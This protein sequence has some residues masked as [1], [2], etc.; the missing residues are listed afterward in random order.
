[1]IGSTHRTVAKSLDRLRQDGWL[2]TV[3]RR[4]QFGKK[5]AIYFPAVPD[6]VLLKNGESL[7]A[8]AMGSPRSPI[9]LTIGES[10]A[11]QS[12]ATV[13]KAANSVDSPVDKLSTNGE[14][15]HGIG[16]SGLE[17][18][19]PG[20]PRNLTEIK[21]KRAASPRPANAGDAALPPEAIAAIARAAP[22]EPASQLRRAG[23]AATAHQVETVRRVG[24]TETKAVQAKADDSEAA[25]IAK[26]Q[27][28][29]AA[30]PDADAATLCVC[31]PGA[32]VDEVERARKSNGGAA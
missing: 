32:T 21:F 28:L 16:E 27:K 11:P 10:I 17:I 29:R 4:R 5:G 7:S 31:V 6:E 20:L 24:A 3:E 30:M 14:S 19:E 8:S 2:H 26:L 12:A 22:G 18:G 9:G 15:A 13:H 1:M 23:Q 25:R